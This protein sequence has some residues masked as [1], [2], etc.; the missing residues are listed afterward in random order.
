YDT[1]TTGT[2]RVFDQI[3]QF[4]AV[5]T[6]DEFN[7]LEH[8][9]LRCRLL[10]HVV[11]S[12][13]AMQVTGVAAAQLLNAELPTHYTMVRAIR[14]K[15]LSWKPTLFIGYNSLDFDENLLRQALYQTLHPPYLTNT[16]GNCRA[17][18]L[19]IARASTLFAPNAL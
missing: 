10:P 17:D 5:R 6:D 7:E 8:F 9:N 13:S 4:A 2:D 11:P 12:P 19:R 3:L 16:D 14:E 18:A 1:E 15:L